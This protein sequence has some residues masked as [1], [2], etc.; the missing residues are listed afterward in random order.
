MKSEHARKTKTIFVV[1]AHLHFALIVF[2]HGWMQKFHRMG[3]AVAP[4]KSTARGF[5]LTDWMAL[6]GW[7]LASAVLEAKW[8]VPLTD[9]IQ[10]IIA[11]PKLSVCT[12][13]VP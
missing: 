13:Y 10:S 5:H 2:A 12:K 6:M 9:I 7:G 4:A 11:F 8:C 1:I 3:V